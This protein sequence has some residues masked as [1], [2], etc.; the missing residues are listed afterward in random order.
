[1]AALEKAKIT[2]TVSGQSIPVMF[3]P[4]EY[5]LK[6]DINYA[7]A[8]VPGLSAP[9]LQFVSGNLQTLDMELTLDTYEGHSAS[10]KTLNEAGD[11]VRDLTRKV[12]ELMDIDPS[13]HAPPVLLFAWG[14]LTFTCVLARVT[15]QFTMFLPDG[16]PVRARLQVTFDEYRNAELE[17]QQVKRET[18]DYT[19]HHVVGQGETLAS[20]AAVA[21]GDPAQWR[22]IA[23]RNEIDVPAA[24]A[25]GTTLI[26][27]ALPYIDPDSGEVLG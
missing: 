23:L 1:M 13:T 18:A 22:P 2:N 25:T 11:D 26:I 27:P 7:Q 6:R 8:A 15:Q 20:I 4:A 12:A 21:Y 9:I 24:I 5:S 14:S 16:T 19:K 10:G 17:A 3:N